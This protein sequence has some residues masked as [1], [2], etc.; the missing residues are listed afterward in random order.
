MP[1]RG[2]SEN[3]I[4]WQSIRT[5]LGLDNSVRL[6]EKISKC[7]RRFRNEASIEYAFE[8]R[9]PRS[10]YLHLSA[11]MVR[12][13]LLRES[14]QASRSAFLRS[15]QSAKLPRK[16]SPRGFPLRGNFR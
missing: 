12:S 7:W 11:Q 13:T 14:T 9:G 16:D 6:L 2:G 8:C 1:L 3:G 5:E 4:R 10:S 15:A